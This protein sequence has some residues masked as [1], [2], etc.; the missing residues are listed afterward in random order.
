MLAFL[1]PNHDYTAAELST[2]VQALAAARDLK[3]YSPPR[4]FRMPVYDEGAVFKKLKQA[5]MAVFLAH[6]ELSLDEVSVQELKIL[7]AAGVR[8]R[9]VAP[10]TV[11]DQIS[12]LA[13]GSSVE[14]YPFVPGQP[15]DLHTALKRIV[16]ELAAPEAAAVPKRGKASND[17]GLALLFFALLIFVVII[18]SRGK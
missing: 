6:D 5:H 2:K 7:A 4:N 9:C 14:V 17:D 18:F 3:V 15:A 12:G 8:T 1:Y 10:M 13:L 11:C 16:D